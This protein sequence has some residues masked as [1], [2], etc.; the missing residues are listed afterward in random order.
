MKRSS[1]KSIAMLLA[2]AMIWGSSFVAQSVSMDYI[3]PF[4][5]NAVRSFLAALCLIPAILL[6]DGLRGKEA[7]KTAPSTREEWKLLLIAGLCCG[8]ALGTATGLQQMGRVYTEA[9][10]AGFLTTLYVVIVPFM[11]VAFLKQRLP[12]V[13]WLCVALAL[14]GLYLLSMAGPM[15]LE[16]GDSMILLCAAAYAV[17]ILVADYFSPRVDPV[18]MSCI[19]FFVCG[20]VSAVMMLLTE[21][22]ELGAILNAW[23]PIAYAGIFSSAVAYTLQVVAQK[24]CDPTVASLLLSLE[25]VF[26][27]VFGCALLGE[28]L[29][30]RELIGCAL[31]MAAIVIAQ[32]PEGKLAWNGKQ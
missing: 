5:F 31:I 18:R 17:H 22:P 8:L 20:L 12:R 19:Q 11:G 13:I 14:G 30:V 4:T 10:K 23:Q 21:Q 29:T 16:F 1:P 32:L 24:E 7:D 15:G 6:L 9:S 26:G 25:S 27:A 28:E 2:T 3:G